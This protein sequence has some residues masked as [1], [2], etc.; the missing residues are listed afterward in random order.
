MGNMQRHTTY[1]LPYGGPTSPKYSSSHSTSSAF[2]ASANPNEDWTKISDLAE[3]RRIQNRIAQRNYRKKIK[4]RLEDLERRAG[5]S[6]ASPEQSHAELAPIIEAK[7][8]HQRNENGVKRQRSK[9]DSAARGRRRS[10]EPSYPP[11]KQERSDPSYGRDFSVS[12]PPSYSY[13]YSLPEPV[14][15]APYPQHAPFNTLP[16]PYPSYS[17]HSQYLPTTLPSMAQYDLGPSKNGYLDDEMLGQYETNYA[18]F[19]SMDLPMHQPYPDSNAHT[20]PLSHSHSFEYSR[21]GSPSMGFP[22]TPASIPDSPR[23][24][25]R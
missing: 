2:S 15:H 18:P 6:S 16:A 12:P 20:P 1:S 9:Q 11:I 10:P 19:G 14:T 13:P 8:S 4:R 24:V 17:G 7:Q 3:R 25:I 5:S 23:L 21:G 22:G